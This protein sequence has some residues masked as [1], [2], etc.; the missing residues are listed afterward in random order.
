MGGVYLR[1]LTQEKEMKS[2]KLADEF[3]N[4]INVYNFLNNHHKQIVFQTL[5]MMDRK[6]KH[7]S[8]NK[9]VYDKIK[10]KQNEL[11]VGYAKLDKELEKLNQERG[12]KYS[13]KTYESVVRRKTINGETFDDIC[14]ILQISKEEKE[15][16]DAIGRSVQFEEQVSIEWLFSSLS[17]KNRN[18]IFILVNLLNM[19]ETLPEYFDP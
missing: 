3:K 7:E 13:T 4:F 10:E 18:A 16:F 14:E 1:F 15:E 8:H 11:N 19:E 17:P 12:T 9:A 2:R 6:F 5:F